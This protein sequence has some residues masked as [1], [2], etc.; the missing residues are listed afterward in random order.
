MSLNDQFTLTFQKILY[1]SV[2]GLRMVKFRSLQFYSLTFEVGVRVLYFLIFW[3]YWEIT[4]TNRTT[5]HVTRS[6]LRFFFLMLLVC[7]GAYKLISAIGSRNNQ[8][9]VFGKL[10]SL[11]NHT[12]LMVECTVTGSHSLMFNYALFRKAFII[13]H[14]CNYKFQ[15]T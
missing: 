1:L 12:Y 14:Q 2:G 8:V 11:Q 13:M 4:L 7:G 5:S 3:I 6:L 9:W 10:V 15:R